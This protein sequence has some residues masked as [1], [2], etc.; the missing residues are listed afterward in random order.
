[1]SISPRV[2]Q[3]LMVEHSLS[4]L[5]AGAG[6]LARTQEQLHT[7]RVLNRPSDSPTDVNAAMRMRSGI[8]GEAQ[9][10][11]NARDGLGWLAQIDNTM[12][13]MLLQ[14]NRAQGLAL[15]GVSTGNSSAASREALAIEVEQLREGLLQQANAT[16]LGR[17]VFGGNTAGPVAYDE[18][19]GAFVGNTNPVQR[20][21]ADGVK[22]AVNVDAHAAFGTGDADIFAVLDDLVTNL[23]TD[24]A[25]I[26]GNIEQLDAAHKQMTSV[27][28][29]VGTRYGRVENAALK[30]ENVKL[31]LQT[32]LSSVENV[33]LA[34]AMVDLR[35][36]ETA[37]QA[38]LA[39]TAR[40]MQPSLLDFLR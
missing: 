14:V 7:G 15:Q 4:S 18:A 33:D 38:A 3:R 25:A 32:T 2:T 27:L 9:H 5:Q 39:T 31:D 19:T 12:Q 11:R 37:Y 36:Q 35:L 30:A 26:A 8:A 17:P 21:V 23:R 20:A 6:R 10:A 16:Y 24:P 22:V 40:V 1:M 34:K 13:S 28:A 29:D